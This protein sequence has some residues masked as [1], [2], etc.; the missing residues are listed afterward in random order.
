MNQMEEGFVYNQSA[1]SVQLG[2]LEQEI[3]RQLLGAEVAGVVSVVE[4]QVMLPRAS[5]ALES[6]SEGPIKNM[7]AELLNSFTA[8][9]KA[10]GVPV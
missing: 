2:Q 6:F 1:G 3:L 10:A 9:L 4:L 8:E 5:Q 7:A